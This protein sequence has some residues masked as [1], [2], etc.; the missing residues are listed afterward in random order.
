MLPLVLLNSHLHSVRNHCWQDKV[1]QRGI[2]NKRLF[3][4]F[5]DK[6]WLQVCNC[7]CN[8]P[9]V[10]S[11]V[12]H[13]QR[14]L[15][16]SNRDS[17]TRSMT[18]SMWM[19]ALEIVFA[20]STCSFVKCF[21]PFVKGG[22]ATVTCSLRNRSCTLKPLSTKATIPLLNLLT[23]PQSSVIK[24]SEAAPPYASDI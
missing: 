15:M 4:S 3:H 13:V 19:R 14:K 7:S 5:S 23:T 10:V 6:G 24:R 1:I 17:V 16:F 2:Q 12:Q 11:E 21:L 22:I 18:L 8:H 9:D 20:L